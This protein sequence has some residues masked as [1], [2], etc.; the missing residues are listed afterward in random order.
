[1]VVT[2]HQT[3]AA[4]LEKYRMMNTTVQAGVGARPYQSINFL[5]VT[6]RLPKHKCPTNQSI[7][8]TVCTGTY[9]S[10]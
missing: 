3:A 5:P 6:M 4:R 2:V 1:M 9:V 8:E 7:Y 10:T